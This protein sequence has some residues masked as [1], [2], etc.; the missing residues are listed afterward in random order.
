MLKSITNPAAAVVEIVSG[1]LNR[2][3][4]V[5]LAVPSENEVQFVVTVVEQVGRITATGGLTEVLR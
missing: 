4:S 2:R 3:L 5:S 1:G